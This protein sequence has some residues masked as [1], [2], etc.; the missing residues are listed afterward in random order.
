MPRL[1]LPANAVSP[2]SN[3]KFAP[4]TESRYIKPRRMSFDLECVDGETR[5]KTWD[6]LSSH[7]AVALLVLD[8]ERQ[9]FVLVRQFRAAVYA[10]ASEEERRSDPDC[11]FTL[12][13]PAGIV[14][15]ALPLSSIAREELLEECGYDCPESAIREITVG[16]GSVGMAASALT[17]FYAEVDGAMCVG[18]GGGLLEE[19]ESIEAVF[20]PV[21]DAE[22]FLETKDG[23]KGFATGMV[24]A[25]YWWFWQ[26]ARS[27]L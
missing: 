17:M 25:F 16:L 21:R 8:T 12:E 4:L 13:L 22:A 6:V 11:G 10:R 3:V 24:A 5:A 9:A 27:R 14:D 2:V 18:P 23:G 7:D 19:G 20:L 15:K 1:G 26:K